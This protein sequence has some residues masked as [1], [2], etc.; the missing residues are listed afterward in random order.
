MNDKT[1][2]S[3]IQLTELTVEGYNFYNLAYDTDKGASLFTLNNFKGKFSL[4]TSSIKSIMLETKVKN[5]F[6]ELITTDK[7]T[8]NE[9]EIDG[10][11][12]SDN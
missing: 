9:L 4:K 10:N 5:N 6:L 1:L 2:K 7:T 12:F 3:I 11:T 8:Q